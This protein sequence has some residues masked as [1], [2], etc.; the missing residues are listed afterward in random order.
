VWQSNLKK[1]VNIMFRKTVLFTL[2]LVLLSSIS[3][4]QGR[5]ILTEVS[6]KPSI[7]WNWYPFQCTMPDSTE[8]D[9]SEVFENYLKEKDKQKQELIF[10]TIIKKCCKNREMSC[11]NYANEENVTSGFLAAYYGADPFVKYITNIKLEKGAL[12]KYGYGLDLLHRIYDLTATMA[13]ARNPNNDL[14][15]AKSMLSF[16]FAKGANPL[17]SNIRKQTLRDVAAAAKQNGIVEWLDTKIL[18]LEQYKEGSP[19]AIDAKN[20]YIHEVVNLAVKNMNKEE[21]KTGEVRKWI[22]SSEIYRA[23]ASLFSINGNKAL[24]SCDGRQVC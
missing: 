6:L 7:D 11:V 5:R 8:K 23:I 1:G 18:S 12:A 4:A 2:A 21:Q 16:A 9:F 22:E 19:A 17:T 20:K 10:N 24:S 15:G 13:M 3:F 14:E